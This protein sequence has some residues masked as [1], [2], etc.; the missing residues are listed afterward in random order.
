MVLPEMIERKDGNIIIISSV[1]GLKGS[2]VL[3]AYDIS[4]AA[5]IMLAKNLA[6]EF[7]PHNVRTNAIAP[8]LFRG[9]LGEP[10]YTQ[11]IHGQLPTKK[12]W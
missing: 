1:G 3:G 11:A 7:G 8:G 4:K 6:I 12:N 5:D 2:A 9:T 10:R